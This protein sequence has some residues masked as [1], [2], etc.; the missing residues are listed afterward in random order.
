MEDYVS[1]LHFFIA[2]SAILAVASVFL[3]VKYLGAKAS[4]SSE[5]TLLYEKLSNEEERYQRQEHA[6]KELIKTKDE[7]IN[8]LRNSI[9]A[10]AET[11]KRQIEELKNAFQSLSEEVLEDKSKKFN[12]MQSETLTGLK[13]D[14]EKFRKAFTES[15]RDEHTQRGLLMR[16]I[17]T[18]KDLNL[19]I[20]EDALNLTKALKNDSK[21]RGNWGEMI[22]EQLL[23]SSG[24]VE[25]E[26][27]FLQHS[28]ANEEG[29]QL[30]PDA[31]IKLPHDKYI[32]VDSKVNLVDYEKYISAEDDTERNKHLAAHIN[33]IKR[34]ISSLSGKDYEKLKDFEGLDFV[35]MFVP[36]EGAITELFRGDLGSE[37]Y[38]EAYKNNVMIVTPTTLMPVLRVIGQLWRNE[39][40]DKNVRE[41]MSQTEKLLDKF[42]VFVGHME[43][44]KRSISTASDAYDS[45][46]ASMQTGR[47]S[48]ISRVQKLSALSGKKLD[49]SSNYLNALDSGDDE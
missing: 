27:Y 42:Q 30:R 31:L 8:D 46:I 1:V 6:H 4:Q 38:F 16:E 40:R 3:L 45:A 18:L 23:Q 5:L 33:S 15:A 10:D 28:I 43:K 9:S 14:I 20:S 47:G 29:K 11:K 2:C 34:H 25:D 24:L 32:V 41:I 21:V 13:E 17:D 12:T 37:L 26:T 48:L 22:L 7:Q 44:V 19:K 35:I 39:L 36:I 49:I